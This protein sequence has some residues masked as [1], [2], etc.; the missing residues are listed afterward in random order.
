MGLRQISVARLRGDLAR[1]LQA[2]ERGGEV[3]VT[4]S[5]RAVAK[6]VPAS[7]AETRLRSVGVHPP[8][9]PGPLPRVAPV[10]LSKG[11]SLTRAVLD[12]RE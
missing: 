12:E 4:R 9:R 6:L 2:V 8:R 11:R 10:R 7:D 5:G 3:L 1:V